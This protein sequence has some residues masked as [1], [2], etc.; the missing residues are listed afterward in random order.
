VEDTVTQQNFDWQKGNPDRWIHSFASSMTGNVDCYVSL[1]YYYCCRCFVDIPSVASYCIGAEDRH[2]RNILIQGGRRVFQIDFGYIW[3]VIPGGG[4]GAGPALPFSKHVSRAL[5]AEQRDYFR[6]TATLLYEVLGVY[7]RELAGLAARFSEVV[8]LDVPI[9][10]NVRSFMLRQLGSTAEF[11][12][13]MGVAESDRG[14]MRK[15]RAWFWCLFV[16]LFVCLLFFI[17]LYV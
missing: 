12:R 5:T 15:G 10:V 4:L 17:F 9:T 16:C 6:A 13:Q 1:C 11:V 3:G 2:S 8:H 7:A 14:R